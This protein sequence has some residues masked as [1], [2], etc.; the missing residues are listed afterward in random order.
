[1]RPGRSHAL[2]VLI[3]CSLL[4]FIN[5]ASLRAQ[6]LVPNGSFEER[7]GCPHS[8]DH[9]SLKYLKNWTAP[10]WKDS[11][12]YSI[13]HTPDYFHSC[14]EGKYHQPKNFMGSQTPRDGKGYTGLL[15]Y[16]VQS[17]EYLQVKLKKPLQKGKTYYIKTNLSQANRSILGIRSFGALLSRDS[18]YYGKNDI[19]TPLNPLTGSP[20]QF[21]EKKKTWQSLVAC[22]T[23]DGGEQFLTLGNFQKKKNLDDTWVG[24]KDEKRDP[25]KKGYYYLD[26]V[27]VMPCD[28]IEDCPCSYLEDQNLE[29]RLDSVAEG[30]SE[31]TRLQ[32]VNIYFETDK[33][34]LLDASSGMLYKLSSFLK[35]NQDFRVVI[36]GHTDKRGSKAYNQKLAKRRAKSVMDFLVDDGVS[37]D[38]LSTKAY[39]YSRPIANNRTPRGRRLNR[40][41]EF[42]IKDQ[43]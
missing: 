30:N 11:G 41:V 29:A 27:A 37:K 32:L 12:G 5:L 14:S 13:T 6:N 1:M 8:N 35:E 33:A 7:E 28:E 23:A 17:R 34:E 43:P 20:D 21:F 16:N 2:P 24:R 25:L 40:R 31:S 39:G 4:S 42:I 36:E 10:E 26:K 9:F 19:Y 22:Y 15:L 18:V 38:R 3:V